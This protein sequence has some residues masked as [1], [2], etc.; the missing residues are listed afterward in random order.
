MARR[1]P[2]DKDWFMTLMKF[3]WQYVPGSQSCVQAWAFTQFVDGK[4]TCQ[5]TALLRIH[6]DATDSA[7]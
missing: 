7:S 2:A 6:A 5:A 4:R 1:T 3:L